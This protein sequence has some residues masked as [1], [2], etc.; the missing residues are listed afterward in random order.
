LVEEND[1]ER[2]RPRAVFWRV[3]FLN[4][5]KS[6]DGRGTYLKDCQWDDET[7][8]FFPYGLAGLGV[9]I[10]WNTA[11]GFIANLPPLTVLAGR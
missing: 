11:P 6:R 10:V 7:I 9:V 4:Q 2:R 8:R 5:F 1:F 3:A